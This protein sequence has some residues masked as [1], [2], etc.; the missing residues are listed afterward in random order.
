MAVCTV[1][2]PCGNTTAHDLTDTIQA[3]LDGCLAQHP[4]TRS[5]RVELQNPRPQV[6]VC[7]FRIMRSITLVND[8]TLVIGRNVTLFS[9]RAGADGFAPP[10]P[11]C[12]NSSSQ[13]LICCTDCSNIGIVG[14][15]RATSVIDGGGFS[16]WFNETGGRN[17]GGTS[18]WV[19]PYW[20]GFRPRTILLDWS[21]DIYLAD[22]TV[23]NSPSGTLIFYFS[24]GILVENIAAL[25]PRWQGNTDG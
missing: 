3:A 22:L 9:G 6:G 15:D 16:W 19:E 11:R 1:D 24:D 12:T 13:G 14:R 4:G 8:T 20:Y 18:G 2:G 21:K 23:R 5:A 10:N 17:P 7:V 25:A